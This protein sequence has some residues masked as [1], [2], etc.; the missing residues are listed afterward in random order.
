MAG[1]RACGCESQQI[2]VRVSECVCVCSQHGSLYLIEPRRLWT[3]G[4]RAAAGPLPIRFGLV[5]GACGV[6]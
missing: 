4:L 5:T 6:V 1:G 3:D 2:G